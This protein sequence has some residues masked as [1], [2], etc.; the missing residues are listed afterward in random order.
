MSN[1]STHSASS[2]ASLTGRPR[3][4]RLVAA[5]TLALS[6]AALATDAPPASPLLP[7]DH[8]ALKAAGRLYEIGLAPAWM[9]AQ[10]AAPFVAVGRTLSEAAQRAEVDAPRHAKLARAWAERFRQEFPRWER[11]GEEVAV[12]PGAAVGAGAELGH[13]SGAAPATK[14]PGSISLRAPSD[15]PFGDLSSAATLGQHVAVGLHVHADRSDVAL[16]SAEVIGTLGPFALSVGRGA[17][18][19]GPNEVG[20]VVASGAASMNRAELMTTVPVQ[21]PGA[22]A[23]LG[24]FALDATLARFS[25]ARHPYRPLLWEFQ[26]QWRPHPRFTFGAARG[27]MFAGT[28]WEGISAKTAVAGFVGV[29]NKAPGNNV[30]SVSARCRLPV[31]TLLPLTLDVEW[32][33]DDNPGAAVQW[34]GLVAGISAPMLGPLPASLGIE[35]A[36]FGRGLV[37]YHDPFPWYSHFAYTGGWVT[38]Q[39]PLGDPLGGNGRALRAIG[40]ADLWDSRIRLSGLGWV[41]DRFVDNLYAPAAVGRSFGARGE[42]EWRHWRGALGIVSSYEWGRDGWNRV[43]VTAEAKLFL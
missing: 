28:P 33:T 35:Y 24:D 4:C 32:G 39:T 5:L 36:Y 9:P 37:G 17:V 41:Q 3:L 40:A 8:W 14:G 21:L 7:P 1:V 42:V 26:L 22:L 13:V 19:Y 43:G 30:Y 6:R 12:L 2:R 20:A 25:D 29:S 34:P 16:P 27:F 18:G 11:A 38:G 23:A 15:G 10:R 31:E